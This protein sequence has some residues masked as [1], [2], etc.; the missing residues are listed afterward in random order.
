LAELS[1]GAAGGTL[2]G[3]LVRAVVLSGHVSEKETETGE[4]HERERER[5]RE[6]EREGVSSSGHS[7]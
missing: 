1:D 2:H 6:R 5:K 4:K 7:H 3:G